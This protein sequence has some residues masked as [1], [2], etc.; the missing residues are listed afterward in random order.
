M[1]AMPSPST[2]SPYGVAD[3]MLGDAGMSTRLDDGWAFPV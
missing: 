3:S 2:V 1:P